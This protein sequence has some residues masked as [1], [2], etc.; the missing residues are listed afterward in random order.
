MK[1]QIEGSHGQENKLQKDLGKKINGWFHFGR[2][3]KGLFT[4]DAD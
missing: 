3:L 4:P 1:I 2:S